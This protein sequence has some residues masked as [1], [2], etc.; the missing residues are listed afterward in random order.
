M[1]RSHNPRGAH[2]RSPN[3]RILYQF[4]LGWFIV[5]VVTL[6]LVGGVLTSSFLKREAQRSNLAQAQL[7]QFFSF[8]YNSMAEE[9]WTHSY[10]AIAKRSGLGK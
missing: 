9:A 2:P 1:A 4:A 10:Q 6:G 8:H 3:I 5:V 7:E